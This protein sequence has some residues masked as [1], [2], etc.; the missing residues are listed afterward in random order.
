MRS[1]ISRLFSIIGKAFSWIPIII[2][3]VFFLGS[4]AVGFFLGILP[5]IIVLGSRFIKGVGALATGDTSDI[6]MTLFIGAIIIYAIV[7]TIIE[8]N[9]KKCPHGIVNGKK[10]I[11]KTGEAKCPLCQAASEAQI[12]QLN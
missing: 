3:L 1:I 9:D 12:K 8:H 5:L 10:V 11:K 6:G 4:M 7:C 2:Q